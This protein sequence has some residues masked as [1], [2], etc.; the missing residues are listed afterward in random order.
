MAAQFPP[1]GS[2][3]C[4]VHV[5]GPKTRFPLAAKRTYTPMDAPTAQLAA[6]L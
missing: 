6:M 4:H 5:I 2:A 1:P 3:D